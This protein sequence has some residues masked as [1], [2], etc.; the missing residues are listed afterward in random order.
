MS[1]IVDALPKI[2]EFTTKTS[3]YNNVKERT[4]F[5]RFAIFPPEATN[6]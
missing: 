6:T 3:P 4:F 1:K 5:Y 2:L